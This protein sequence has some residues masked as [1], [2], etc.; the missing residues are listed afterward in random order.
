MRY[1]RTEGVVRRKTAYTFQFE[2]FLH[3]HASSNNFLA[4]TTTRIRLNVLSLQKAMG[5][6]VDN[7]SRALKRMGFRETLQ[8]DR[9]VKIVLSSI[10]HTFDH[11]S[12]MPDLMS[13]DLVTSNRSKIF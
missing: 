8:Y 5:H 7:L 1:Y 4:R 11:N 9:I 6:H 2:G 10:A 13:D 3:V 12:T